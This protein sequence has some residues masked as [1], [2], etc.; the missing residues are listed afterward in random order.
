[1]VRVTAK[2][3]WFY[4]LDRKTVTLP[5]GPC[6]RTGQITPPPYLH[7][8]ACREGIAA[9]PGRIKLAPKSELFGACASS[10]RIAAAYAVVLSNSITLDK[11]AFASRTCVSPIR[12]GIVG[13]SSPM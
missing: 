5:I 13:K 1:M 11:K 12:R 3:R 10:A 6:S 2:R 7:M 9:N 8:C 4:R